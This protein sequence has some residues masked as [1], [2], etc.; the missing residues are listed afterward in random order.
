MIHASQM[1]AI[2]RSDTERD[3]FWNSVVCYLRGTDLRDWSPYGHTVTASGNAAV[4]DAANFPNARGYIFDGTTDYLT[5]PHHASLD[6]GSSAFFIEFD[7]TLLTVTG[8]HVLL[9]KAPTAAVGAWAVYQQADAIGFYCSTDGSSWDVCL[10]L[11]LGSGLGTNTRWRFGIYRNGATTKT[12]RDGSQI[13][14]KTDGSSG[15]VYASTADFLVGAAPDGSESANA[16]I[17]EIRLTAAAR[18]SAAY[19]PLQG[20]YPTRQG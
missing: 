20:T 14:T 7:L 10:N 15:A 16:R 8:N 6:F 11:S 3:P 13:A 9:R 18:Y 17:A 4:G 5:I 2:G 19:T 12:F 1:G